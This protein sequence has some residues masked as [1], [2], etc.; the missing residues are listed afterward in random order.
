MQR[1]RRAEGWIEKAN[2]YVKEYS[3][4]V[5]LSMPASGPVVSHCLLT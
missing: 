1:G 2:K 4:A 5:G 3:V